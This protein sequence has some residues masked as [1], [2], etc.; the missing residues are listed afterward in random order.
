MA[1]PSPGI[2]QRIP[3]EECWLVSVRQQAYVTHGV[4]RRVQYFELHRL[5]HFD[6]IPGAQAAGHIGDLVS[7][8][9]VRQ[10]L[11]SGIPDHLLV[12]ARM[13]AMFVSVQDL[14][15]IPALFLG[16]L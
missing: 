13:V 3:A 14:G 7:G 16:G 12:P 11:G 10:D 6:D 8:I 9:L 4:A 15:N 2:E 5:A 1:I